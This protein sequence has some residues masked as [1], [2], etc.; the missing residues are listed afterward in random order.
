[1][2]WLFYWMLECLPKD[3]IMEDSMD[4][5]LELYHTDTPE[6]VNILRAVFIALMTRIEDVQLLVSCGLFPPYSFTPVSHFELVSVI[7]GRIVD[8]QELNKETEITKQRREYIS[9]FYQH[10]LRYTTR[11][12]NSAQYV[13]YICS[14]IQEGGVHAL[15]ENIVREQTEAFEYAGRSINTGIS[16]TFNAKGKES[17]DSFTGY[18][19]SLTTDPSDEAEP[20]S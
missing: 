9:G 5:L 17:A 7:L 11:S 14:M 19:G 4:I 3:R 15:Y 12:I 10:T 16:L 13:H 6:S 1:M 20:M 2:K 18:E 8:T